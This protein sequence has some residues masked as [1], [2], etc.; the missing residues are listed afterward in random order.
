MNIL[1]FLKNRVTKLKQELKQN[2]EDTLTKE[3][4]ETENKSKN[5]L[6]DCSYCHRP[7]YEGD[8]WSKQAGKYFHRNCYK[9]LKRKAFNGGI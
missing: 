7:M 3:I 6:Q 2:K 9:E 1:D 8:K 5:Y 4:T